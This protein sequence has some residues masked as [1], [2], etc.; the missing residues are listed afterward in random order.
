MEFRVGDR[1]RVT[2]DA[3]MFGVN[4]IGRCGELVGFDPDDEEYPYLVLLDG[5][6]DD[7]WVMDIEK[8]NT[9]E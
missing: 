8:E 9:H 3:T 7:C 4:Y 1:I 6:T 2:N 5:D